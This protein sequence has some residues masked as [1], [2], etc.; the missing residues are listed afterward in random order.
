M[1]AGGGVSSLCR[2]FNVIGKQGEWSGGRASRGGQNVNT[3][4]FFDDGAEAPF[5]LPPEGSVDSVDIL[6]SGTQQSKKMHPN[7]RHPCNS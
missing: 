7:T 1:L 6:E 4:I 2:L 5:L 3:C